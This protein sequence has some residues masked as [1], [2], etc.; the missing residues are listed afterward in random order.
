MRDSDA[1]VNSEKAELSRVSSALAIRRDR[2][3]NHT[4]VRTLRPGREAAVICHGKYLFLQDLGTPWGRDGRADQKSA[5]R[6]IAPSDTCSEWWKG[7][8]YVSILTF[9]PYSIPRRFIFSMSVVLFICRRRAA[10]LFTPFVWLRAFMISDFSK[11]LT[12]VS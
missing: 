2:S 7:V 8:A 3:K 4:N 9:C 10:W 11:S 12:S 6:R 1:L 5:L